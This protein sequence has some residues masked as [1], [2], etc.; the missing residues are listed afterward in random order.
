MR[1]SSCR[2]SR[3]VGAASEASTSPCLLP[4]AASRKR[5]GVRYGGGNSPL[6]PSDVQ[7]SA[8]D[9]RNDRCTTLLPLFFSLAFLSPLRC[10]TSP[11]KAAV[12]PAKQDRE[13]RRCEQPAVSPNQRTG[14]VDAPAWHSSTSYLVN[15]HPHPHTDTQ[16]R[17][18]GCKTRGSI[19]K[20]KIEH[21]HKQAHYACISSEGGNQHDRIRNTGNETITEA[22]KG[23][24]TRVRLHLSRGLGFPFLATVINGCHGAR[25]PSLPP[26]PS[27]PSPSPDFCASKPPASRLLGKAEDKGHMGLHQQNLKLGKERDNSNGLINKRADDS[28]CASRTPAMRFPLLLARPRPRRP[29]ALGL[30]YA[31]SRTSCARGREGV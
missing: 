21:T 25:P 16:T 19:I 23:A 20:V 4:R 31:Q 1:V 12:E 13:E 30:R 3:D 5:P 28:P 9:L 11:A 10:G 27:P 6:P 26:Y 18:R 8:A 2:H 22:C 15:T 17:K 29:S 7:R 14:R 24:H